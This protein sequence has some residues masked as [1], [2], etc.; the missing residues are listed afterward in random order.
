MEYGFPVNGGQFKKPIDEVSVEIFADSKA[1]TSVK[2][3]L[4]TECV[5]G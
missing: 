2:D 5:P 4:I 3:L 1:K